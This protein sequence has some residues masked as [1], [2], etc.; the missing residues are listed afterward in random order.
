MSNWF[1]NKL[2]KNKIK[3]KLI[4]IKINLFAIALSN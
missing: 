1:K 3:E 2:I 4:K